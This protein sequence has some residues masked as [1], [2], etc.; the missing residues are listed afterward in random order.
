MILDEWMAIFLIS[1]FNINKGFFSGYLNLKRNKPT[2]DI[3]I[4]SLYFSQYP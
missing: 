3:V 1:W 2:I 4:C